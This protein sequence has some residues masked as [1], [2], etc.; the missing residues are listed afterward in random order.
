MKV[1]F[2]ALFA[3]VCLCGPSRADIRLPNLLSDHAVLQRDRPVHLW[4]W[5]APGARLTLQFHG[6]RTETVANAMG[7]WSATLLPEKAGGPY[8][9]TIDGDG[10]AEVRDLVMGDVWFASGQSNMEIPLSGFGASAPIKNG[11]AEIAAATHPELRLLLE[12][13]KSSDLPQDDIEGKWAA[14][15]PETAAKFSAV[16]YFFGRE[17]LGPGACCDWSD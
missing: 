5:S 3:A 8:V 13:R 4:G 16:A 9:L 2:T 15:T 14:C 10:H 7:A 6:Q 11:E 1:V 12:G 17:D